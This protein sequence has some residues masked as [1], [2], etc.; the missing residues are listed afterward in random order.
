MVF[1]R[2]PRSLVWHFGKLSAII[3]SDISSVSYCFFLLEFS[4]CIFIP[5]IVTQFL[6]YSVSFFFLLTFQ[7]WKFLLTYF[8][9]HLFLTMS[10]LLMNQLEAPFT[11]VTVLFILALKKKILPRVFISL[12]T[13]L[14]YSFLLV[15]CFI[16]APSMS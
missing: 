4:L 14:I 15:I 12:V 8:Q 2:H 7:F 16:R 1:F 13:Y 5:L 6:E 11:S 3:N 10:C 9:G